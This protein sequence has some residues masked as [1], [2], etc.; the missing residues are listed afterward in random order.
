[1]AGVP[2]VA[3]LTVSDSSYLA[4]HEDLSGP[5][6]LRRVRSWGWRAD[7]YEIVPDDPEIISAT[8]ARLADG[9]EVDLILTTGGTGL[10][11]RDR[12]PEAT[13][14][15]ADRLAT[16]IADWLRLRSAAAN[17]HAVLSRGQA[18]LRGRTLIVNLP[19]S[20]GAVEEMLELLAVIL[21]HALSQAAREHSWGNRQSHPRPG[22]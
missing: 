5:A 7:T 18:A 21:P 14:A 6:C 13:Q 15:V 10:S 12:T 22:E 11:P 4:L 1:M 16:G 8:L 9:G 3:V 20:P 19:G 2:R 17:P